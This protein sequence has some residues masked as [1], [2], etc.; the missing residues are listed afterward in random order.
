MGAPLGGDGSRELDIRPTLQE[1]RR[2]RYSRIMADTIEKRVSDLEQIL[3]HLP[4]DLDARFAGADARAGARFDRLSVR[5]QALEKR[6]QEGA[7]SAAAQLAGV[8][9]KVDKLAD[10][11]A[12]ILQRLPPAP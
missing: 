3:A 2:T 11:V 4:D 6:V 9:A 8:E 1:R 12:A 10:Q 5:L 7:T